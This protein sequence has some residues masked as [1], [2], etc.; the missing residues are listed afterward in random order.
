M[1]ITYAF[2]Q[3]EIDISVTQ[4]RNFIVYVLLQDVKIL[5]H[6]F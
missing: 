4:L 3:T 5:E 1:Y 6:H 2:K